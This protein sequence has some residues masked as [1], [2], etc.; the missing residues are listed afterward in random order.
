MDTIDKAKPTLSLH[1][2]QRL[3]GSELATVKSLFEAAIKTADDSG[4]PVALA[5]TPELTADILASSGSK[6][7]SVTAN[8]HVG[9]VE[10]ASCVITV[11]PKPLTLAAPTANRVGETTTFAL[12]STLNQR[13]QD[14]PETARVGAMQ[15]P[16]SR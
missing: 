7:F 9:N 11:T 8:D 6:V 12:S 2:A 10:T 4:R 16:P 3:Q 5:Y 15:N 1:A 13:Q 14:R